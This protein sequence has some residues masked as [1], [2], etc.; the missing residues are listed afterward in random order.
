MLA[1]NRY[2]LYLTHSKWLRIVNLVQSHLR[3]TTIFVRNEGVVKILLYGRYRACRSVNID[4][5]NDGVIHKVECS[6]IVQPARMI[7]MLVREQY[8]IDS[9]HARTQHLL[10]EVGPR[11]DHNAIAAH[12]DHSR[13]A[14]TIVA[15]ILRSAHLA[16]AADDRHALRCSRT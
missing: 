3:H 1:A 13:R 11:I 8:R 14:Q 12:L 5:A 6:H 7:L 15:L 16:A 4:G 10:T 2:D 9:S